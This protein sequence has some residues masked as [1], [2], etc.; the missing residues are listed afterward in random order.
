MMHH[1]KEG[2]CLPEPNPE[3][4]D[5]GLGRRQIQDAGSSKQQR[6]PNTH[7]HT[8]RR[9]RSPST[10]YAVCCYGVR[11]CQVPVG[12]FNGL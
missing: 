6:C 1:A 3:L 2:D 12:P 10:I 4:S 7:A 11:C 8:H 9:R 5:H